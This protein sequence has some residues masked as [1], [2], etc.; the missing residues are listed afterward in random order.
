MCNAKIENVQDKIPDITNLAT[1]T[2]L[3]AKINEL[4][5]QIPSI[6]NIATTALTDVE[7]K[8]L[9]LVILTQK[10]VKLKIHLLLTMINILLLKKNKSYFN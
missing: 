6:Y 1:N 5:S 4:K 7:I 8:C 9:M 10:L 3:H 2:T